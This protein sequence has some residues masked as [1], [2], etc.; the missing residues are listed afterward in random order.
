MK[1]IENKSEFVKLNRPGMLSA[2]FS[3]GTWL[4]RFL[5]LSLS[6]WWGRLFVLSGAGARPFVALQHGISSIVHEGHLLS[7]V[8]QACKWDDIMFNKPLW[9]LYCTSM[10]DEMSSERWRGTEWEGGCVCMWRVCACMHACARVLVFI[11]LFISQLFYFIH[12]QTSLLNRQ[13]P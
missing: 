4:S 9:S 11:L 10:K 8:T 6:L 3:G 13:C 2:Y 12:M 5:S 7:E 1:M